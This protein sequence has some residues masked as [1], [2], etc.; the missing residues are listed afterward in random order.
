MM[1]IF[2]GEGEWLVER[3]HSIECHPECMEEIGLAN[4]VGADN[5]IH[6]GIQMR[7]LERIKREV[8]VNGN[9]IQTHS[10]YSFLINP[11]SLK[12]TCLFRKI[13]QPKYAQE[14]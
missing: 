11:P 14:K 3:T 4:P 8:I 1:H 10:T 9:T 2:I 5:E 6:I 12:Y 13:Q 7:P